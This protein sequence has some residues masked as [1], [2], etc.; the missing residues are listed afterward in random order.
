MCP[1]L[2]YLKSRE[3]VG[4]YLYRELLL[5]TFLTTPCYFYLLRF[6]NCVLRTDGK[7]RCWGFNMKG[8]L[9]QERGVF[10]IGGEL[11]DLKD[12]LDTDLK[13]TVR[14]LYAGGNHFCAL[15]ASGK[16]KCWGT[17]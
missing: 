9:G 6:A 11:K 10:D 8:Q 12:N 2:H 5:S 14:H 3:L 15:S 7:V 13:M 4:L 17:I 1:R 16:I